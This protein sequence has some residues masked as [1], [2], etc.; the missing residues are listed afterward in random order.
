MRCGCKTH[1]AQLRAPRANAVRRRFA[2][3]GIARRARRR[4][5][6]AKGRP[7]YRTAF[8]V[9]LPGSACDIALHNNVVAR[10]CRRPARRA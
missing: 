2:E 1:V 5:I 3:R 9:I 8:A 7:Y 10:D 6:A 4:S